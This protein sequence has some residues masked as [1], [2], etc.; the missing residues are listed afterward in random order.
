MKWLIRFLNWLR[1]ILSRRVNETAL[2]I[3]IPGELLYRKE[4]ESSIEV[5]D[6][7]S[8]IFDWTITFE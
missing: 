7:E 1:R 5:K 3:S 2:F 6:G 4:L 8:I